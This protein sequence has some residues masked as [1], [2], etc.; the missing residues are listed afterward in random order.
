MPPKKI[1][2]G[3][4]EAEE[5]AQMVSKLSSLHSWIK[6]QTLIRPTKLG[7]SGGGDGGPDDADD[8]EFVTVYL[9]SRDP[10][11]PIGQL[12]WN[13]MAGN[14][15]KLAFKET[16]IS[17]LEIEST[18]LYSGG[19]EGRDQILKYGIPIPEDEEEEDKAARL[20][21]LERYKPYM[22]K[23]KE[24][25]EPVEETNRTNKFSFIERAT[26][27]KPFEQVHMTQQTEPPPVDVFGGTV[28]PCIIFDYYMANMVGEE[29]PAKTEGEAK[30]TTSK[31]ENK[32]DDVDK[33]AKLVDAKLLLSAKMLERMVNLDTFDDIA[34]DYR[35]YEDP[36]DEHRDPPDGVQLILL[37]QHM[38]LLFLPG[39]AIDTDSIVQ[40]LLP[41]WDFIVEEAAGL[42]V[43]GLQ[44]SPKYPG[45]LFIPFEMRSY[46]FQICLELATVPSTSTSSPGWA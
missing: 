7:K 12:K 11:A 29:E 13:H 34:K 28:S 20:A 30:K 9:S 22:V 39:I 18:I 35:F 38:S 3:Q 4:T 19:V 2:T 31:G 6:A 15:A 26:Q 21:I 41:L 17:H 14:H 46:Y 5:V 1:V 45:S 42:E 37:F 43:T 32:E 16:M 25:A 27:T 8:E 23:K 24:E 44:W 10:E 33:D 36:G 40:V